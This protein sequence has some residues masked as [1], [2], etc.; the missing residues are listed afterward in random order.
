VID[1][2]LFAIALPFIAG[3]LAFRSH[4]EMVIGLSALGCGLILAAVHSSVIA[5][6]RNANASAMLE[7]TEARRRERGA[8]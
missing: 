3:G 8:L 1:F 7:A 2:L 5:Y 4:T 6:R